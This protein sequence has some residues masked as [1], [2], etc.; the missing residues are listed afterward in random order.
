MHTNEKTKV[1]SYV[2]A[3]SAGVRVFECILVEVRVA[4]PCSGSV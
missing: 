4:A 1:G 3:Y 2:V